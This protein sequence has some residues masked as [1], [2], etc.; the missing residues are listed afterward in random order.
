MNELLFFLT[1]WF[2]SIQMNKK[3]LFIHIQI[4]IVSLQMAFPWEEKRF[5]EIELLGLRKL[6]E[7]GRKALGLF[8]LA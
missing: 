7:S 4:I 6:D 3:F 5:W 2:I 8:Q 1:K